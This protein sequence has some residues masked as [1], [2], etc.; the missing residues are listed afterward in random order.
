MLYQL[1]VPGF[2]GQRLE[3]EA[4]AFKK[5]LLLN[6]VKAP[7]AGVGKYRLTRNDGREVTTKW[8]SSLDPAPSIV[9]DGQ[10]VRTAPALKWYEMVVVGA[11]LLLVVVGGAIGGLLGAVAATFNAKLIR[12]A[13]PAAVRYVGCVIVACIAAACYVLIAGA[14]HLALAGDH[15][16]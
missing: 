5:T 13:Q 9:I 8:A 12:S 1:E 16:K 3:I 2:E 6:G 14:L 10:T 7:S 15:L 4:G 11:P